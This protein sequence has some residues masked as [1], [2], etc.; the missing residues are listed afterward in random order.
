MLF[1]TSNLVEVPLSF[2][3]LLHSV[4]LS[5]LTSCSF[6]LLLSLSLSPFRHFLQQN[7][8]L[9]R[10]LHSFALKFIQLPFFPRLFSPCLFL[11]KFSV[12]LFGNVNLFNRSFHFIYLHLI[13]LALLSPTFF[14]IIF[15]S[16]LFLSPSSLSSSRFRSFCVFSSSSVCLFWDFVSAA[17]LRFSLCPLFSV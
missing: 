7:P 5:P 9:F 8:P 6:Y 16:R 1:E 11:P 10:A 17:F 2:T 14:T 4:S 3:P 12:K 13:S 15:C